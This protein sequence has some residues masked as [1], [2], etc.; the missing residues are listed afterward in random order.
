[1][2]LALTC[3][4]YGQEQLIECL[5]ASPLTSVRINSTVEFMVL[6]F[7]GTYIFQFLKGCKTHRQTPN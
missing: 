6:V 4:L 1:M 3:A 5:N 7:L 2:L